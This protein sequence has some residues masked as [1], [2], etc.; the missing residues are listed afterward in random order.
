MHPKRPASACAPGASDDDRLDLE[1]YD[2]APLYKSMLRDF[3]AAAPRGAA[4]AAAAR[5]RFSCCRKSAVCWSIAAS[6]DLAAG[7]GLR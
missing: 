7:G 6:L 3:L 4:A 1:V 5:R 2:D